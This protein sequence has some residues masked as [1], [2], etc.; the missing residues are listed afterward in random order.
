[1]SDSK[2]LFIT[3]F[4]PG[5][6]GMIG[7]GEILSEDS[8][9][10]LVASGKEVHLLCLA[11]NNQ[12]ANADVIALCK[13]YRLSP[14]TIGHACLG[15][16]SGTRRGALA[17][18]W[19]F[20][21]TS[22]ANVRAAREIISH[23]EIDRVLLDFPSTLGFAPHLHDVPVEY[24][25]HDVLAQ[26]IGRRKI[27]GVL[28]PLVQKTEQKLLAFVRRC[29][30]ISQK[31]E[32]LLRELGFQGEIEQRQISGARIGQVPDGRPISEILAEFRG[33]KNLVFFGNMRRPE[34]HWS[35]LHFLL[36]SFGKIRRCHPDVQFWVL[37]LS[38]RIS[39]R[40]LAR[41][42]PGVRVV[43]A[44]DDPGPAFRAAD[45]CVVP[46]R[47]GAGVKIKVLQMLNAGG[48]VVAS[49]VGGEGVPSSANLS[50]V[51]YNDIPDAVCKI[52]SET[53]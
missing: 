37:G 19:L 22:P 33:R 44:V 30:V 24:F 45:L 26:K 31:D 6:K 28:G 38:P 15:I 3:A 7:A 17:V 1:M 53:R 5:G 27:L 36:F 40:V 14:H 49:P 52:L 39:L 46:L 16:L 13:S 9:R 43:G 25:V 20:T 23:Q 18:P 34:N 51:P 10:S 2:I 47:L 48:K 8:I 42:I 4:H 35:I 12:S 50:V 41:M 11:P 32:A 29:Q 21:R